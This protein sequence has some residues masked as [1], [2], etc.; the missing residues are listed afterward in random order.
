[1]TDALWP[2]RTERLEIRPAAAADLGAIWEYRRLPEVNR[3]LGPAPATREAFDELYLDPERLATTLL[4][5]RQQDG[6]VIGDLMLRIG[7][8]WAQ[9]EVIEQAKGTEAE[10][11][12]TLA[13]EHTGQGYATEAV[14]GVIDLCFGALGLRRVLRRQRAVLAHDGTPR[15]AARGAQPQDGAA[16]LRRVDGRHELRPAR[17]GVAGLRLTP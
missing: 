17:G 3:W 5:T 1:M 16:S 14:R 13:P 2:L 6:A 9:R 11:G 15:D 12:W 8:A 4:I 7:D 10:L